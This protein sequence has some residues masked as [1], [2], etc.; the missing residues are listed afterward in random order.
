MV[1]PYHQ[2]GGFAC[3]VWWK[4]REGVEGH[5][6]HGSTKLQSVRGLGLQHGREKLRTGRETEAAN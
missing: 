5:K 1:W 4:V 2:E 6:E 3:L